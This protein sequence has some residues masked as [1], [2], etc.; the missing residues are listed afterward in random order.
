[1]QLSTVTQLTTVLPALA[2][3]AQ[4][5]DRTGRSGKQLRLYRPE[6]T[7]LESSPIVAAI[8]ALL[9]AGHSVKVCEG[10]RIYSPTLSGNQ[11]VWSFR[12]TN[13]IRNTVTVKVTLG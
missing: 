11:V 12:V 6:S 13:K 3:I 7:L 4:G 5:C 1:M 10:D 8:H 2:T 9:A